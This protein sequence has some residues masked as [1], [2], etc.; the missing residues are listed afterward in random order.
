MDANELQYVVCHNGVF[1]LPPAVYAALSAYARDGFVYLRQDFD[2][3]TISTSRVLD[4]WRKKINPRL[5]VTMFRDA[6]ELGIVDLHESIQL[7]AL[8]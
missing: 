6:R 5:R 7:M 1:I 2:V 3:L 4:G 8:R